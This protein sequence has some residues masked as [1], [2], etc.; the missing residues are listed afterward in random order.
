MRSPVA[1]PPGRGSVLPGGSCAP[2]AH[3]PA[4]PRPGALPRCIVHPHKPA[5]PRLVPRLGPPTERWHRAPPPPRPCPNGLADGG[6]TATR[7]VSRTTPTGRR[8]RCERLSPERKGAGLTDA[9]P[10]RSSLCDRGESST[11]ARPHTWTEIERLRRASPVPPRTRRLRP[12]ACRRGALPPPPRLAALTRTAFDKRAG[13]AQWGRP[14]VRAARGKVARSPCPVR[15][16]FRYEPSRPRP[17]R[18]SRRRQARGAG[19]S[20]GSSCSR[21]RR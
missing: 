15:P 18:P 6:R 19:R 8:P 7:M 9:G 13:V 12:P 4:A 3:P 17:G 1:R 14:N 16:E 21:A 2:G 5:P 10:E 20:P 11:R